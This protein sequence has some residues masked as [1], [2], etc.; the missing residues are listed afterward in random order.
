MNVILFCK[1][2][3]MKYNKSLI[4]SMIILKFSCDMLLC[5][6]FCFPFNNVCTY[7]YNYSLAQIFKLLK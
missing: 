4:H 6:G 7:S 2:I 3:L 1:C 5:F